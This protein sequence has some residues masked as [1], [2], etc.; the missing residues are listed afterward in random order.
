MKRFGLVI[1]VVAISLSAFASPVLAAAPGND[2]IDNPIVVGALPFAD[3][4]SGT[5]E[6]TTGAT[7]P[8]SCDVPGGGPDRSTVWY[9]FTPTATAAYAADTFGSDYDTTLYVGTSNG[10]GGIDVITCDDDSSTGLQAAVTWDGVEG[11]TYL[12]MVGTCCGGGTVGQSG[13]GGSVEFHLD[14]APPAPTIDLTV[15]STGSFTKSGT[16]IIR[17]TIACTGVVSP[18]VIPQ[19]TTGGL[20]SIDASQSVG[21]RTIRGSSSGFDQQCPTAVTPWTI[22]VIGDN[23]RFGGGAVQ[24]NAFASACGPFEC[25]DASV[26]RT[27]RLRH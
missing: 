3:G 22:E 20:I 26:S 12:L 24:V 21:R 4:P 23:G 9:A 18:D 13:G 8:G 2:S 6:A 1:G 15:D 27:V 10:S 7:D 5:T 16:A 14:V 25:V 11:T 17:G 19:D